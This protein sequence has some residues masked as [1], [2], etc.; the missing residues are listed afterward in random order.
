MDPDRVQQYTLEGKSALVTGSSRGIGREIAL[1]LAR[2][3][4]DVAISYLQ[5][6]TAAQETADAIKDLGRRALAVRTNLAHRQEIDRLFD[7]VE[8]EFGHLDVFVSN[9]VSAALRPLESLSDRHWDHILSAN[10]SAFYYGGV[11]AIRLMP[12]GGRIIAISSLGSRLYLPGYAALG[13]AKAGLE[14]LARYMAVEWVD[15]NINV[16]VVCGGPV[17]TQAVEA[18]SAAG[19][20]PNEL[21]SQLA[22]RTPAGR[23]G[24]PE[25]IAEL[26]AFLCTSRADWIRGQTIVADGGLSLV[27]WSKGG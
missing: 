11:R 20:D 19:I 18:F 17:D 15:R 8:S 22:S 25:D 3:G 27:G 13:V 26:V 2:D 6:A 4:A 12:A 10:L 14:A 21:K 24:K 5:N 7:E 23:L 1:T 9:A 16:N